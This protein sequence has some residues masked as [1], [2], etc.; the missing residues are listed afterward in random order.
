MAILPPHVGRPD[1]VPGTLPS[2]QDTPG[3]SVRQE[4]GLSS[5]PF[6]T[7][8]APP[9]PSEGRQQVSDG[10]AKT[11]M[12]SGVTRTP[13]IAQLPFKDGLVGGQML[14]P[15]TH[16]REVWAWTR[17]GEVEEMD[18]GPAANH[19]KGRGGRHS[20]QRPQWAAGRPNAQ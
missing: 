7:C 1:T 17:A 12:P 8:S 9:P 15:E 14:V 10:R 13:E 4:K 3:S 2:S 16:S 18:L 19:S 11:H 5:R 6:L 20:L